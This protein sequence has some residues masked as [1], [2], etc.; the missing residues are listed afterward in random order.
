M[1][2]VGAEFVKSSIGHRYREV[3]TH[4]DLSKVSVEKTLRDLTAQ[5]GKDE[6]IDIF[7]MQHGPVHTPF[8]EYPIS[9]AVK[10]L[11]ANSV[12]NLY[13]TACSEWGKLN[14]Q[15]K[16]VLTID[17]Y[18]ETQSEYAL[19]NPQFYALQA[20]DNYSGFL[21]LP[22][23]MMEIK[24]DGNW[25]RATLKSFTDFDVITT[26]LIKDAVDAIN[27]GSMEKA[28]G[29]DI[30]GYVK[31]TLPSTI[32][33][34][35]VLNSKHKLEIE[36]LWY[37]EQDEFGYYNAVPGV[38]RKI[39]KQWQKWCPAEYEEGME[40]RF[41]G[42]G[43]PGGL[44]RFV[45]KAAGLLQKAFV[46]ISDSGDGCISP[47]FANV[48]LK[49]YFD[50]SDMNLAKVCMKERSNGYRLSWEWEKKFEM[51]DFKDV[52]NLRKIKISKKGGLSLINN[53]KLKIRLSG[54]KAVLQEEVLGKVRG[55]LVTPKGINIEDD[56]RA[57]ARINVAGI[58][59][60]G[61]SAETAQELTMPQA[62]KLLGIKVWSEKE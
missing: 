9:E 30:T 42:S 35:L 60:V 23:L 5:L 28:L 59:P 51:R 6:K 31:E 58:L 48:F 15:W 27:D 21:T 55:L 26:D 43:K 41:T 14:Y 33:S 36:N 4:T 32:Q 19:L 54:I 44:R 49:S 20:N 7:T 22:F 57:T 61:V 62:V 38:E 52:P 10:I 47:S 12:R 40:C 56:G 1:E 16:C 3:V 13:S 24:K 34:R 45:E 37:Q 17:P 53:Q 2:K 8:I 18:T 39:L 50:S 29:E 11:P 46:G 25:P